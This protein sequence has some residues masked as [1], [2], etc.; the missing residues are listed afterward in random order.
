MK[1]RKSRVLTE[2][3]KEQIFQVALKEFAEKGY[4]QASTNTICKEAGVAKGL[5]FHYY[6]SKGG[7]YLSLLDKGVDKFMQIYDK[8]LPQLAPDILKRIEQILELKIRFYSEDSLFSSLL[9]NAF[10]DIPTEL[11]GEIRNKLNRMYEK[12][13]PRLYEHLD[14]EVFRDGIDPQKAIEFVGLI[15]DALSEKYIKAYKST[16]DKKYLNLESIKVEMEI[17]LDMLRKGIYK[18]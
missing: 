12:Y 3:K 7:L 17:Y 5:L 6:G 16:G 8:M 10:I 18:G 4:E 1:K 11:E 15:T 13:L 14:Y 2:E 9:V